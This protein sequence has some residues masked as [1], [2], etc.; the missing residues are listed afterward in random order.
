MGIE[1]H[2]SAQGYKGIRDVTLHMQ[3]E[4]SCHIYT[5]RE[6]RYPGPAYAM[7]P[8]ESG[9]VKCCEIVLGLRV[10][11]REEHQENLVHF[12]G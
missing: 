12:R 1:R 6:L 3:R 9:R 2:L 8:I 5:M 7:G 11:G 10:R 4:P